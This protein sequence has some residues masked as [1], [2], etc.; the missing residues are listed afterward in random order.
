VFAEK[1][2]GACALLDKDYHVTCI[3]GNMQAQ[4]FKAGYNGIGIRPQLL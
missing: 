4:I 1:R 2:A 3:L